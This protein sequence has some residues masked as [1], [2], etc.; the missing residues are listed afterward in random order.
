MDSDSLP[1]RKRAERSVAP[2]AENPTTT[3]TG[4]AG[5]GCAKAAQQREKTKGKK[6]KQAPDTFAFRLSTFAFT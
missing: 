1:A 2:P 3:R 5:N 6:K 4:F